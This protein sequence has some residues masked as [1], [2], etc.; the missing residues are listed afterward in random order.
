MLG[1]APS[2]PQERLRESSYPASH[3]L[4]QFCLASIAQSW[5]RCN[6]V[7]LLDAV[8]ESILEVIGWLSA[9]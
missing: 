6:G 8:M 7:D 4:C 1:F 2:I 9:A 5:A 3:L